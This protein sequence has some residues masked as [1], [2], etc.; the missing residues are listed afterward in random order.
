MPQGHRPGAYR[1]MAEKPFIAW[2]RLWA[3]F[4]RYIFLPPWDIGKYETGIGAPGYSI[5]RLRLIAGPFAENI[6]VV[7]FLCVPNSRH[8]HNSAWTPPFAECSGVEAVAYEPGLVDHV[9]FFPVG[10]RPFLSFRTA[11]DRD[12]I[13]ETQMRMMA[14]A[15]P[16]FNISKLGP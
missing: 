8:R 15:P 2:R 12:Q 4:P 16:F 9:R 3:F 6:V 14:F 13:T 5:M 1:P 7:V 10:C 11:L